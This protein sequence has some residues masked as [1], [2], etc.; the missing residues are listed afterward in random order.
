MNA[1]SFIS[2]RRLPI[3]II[4]VATTRFRLWKFNHDWVLNLNSLQGFTKISLIPTKKPRAEFRL[5]HYGIEKRKCTRHP[6]TGELT[7]ETKLNHHFYN[8][9]ALF[10][11]C[12]NGCFLLKREEFNNMLINLI[13]L[14]CLFFIC[15]GNFSEDPPAHISLLCI[16]NQY[17]VSNWHKNK[18]ILYDFSYLRLTQLQLFLD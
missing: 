14:F 10:Y 6:G 17:F 2:L 12:W 11:K 8:N 5:I 7:W 13:S 15:Q 9:C 16:S 4:F 18:I 1:V 3:L